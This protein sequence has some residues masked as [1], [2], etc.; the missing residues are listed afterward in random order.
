MSRDVDQPEGFTLTGIQVDVDGLAAFRTMLHLEL[1][2]NLRPGAQRIIN[3]Q[4]AGYGFGVNS[5]SAAVNYAQGLYVDALSASTNNLRMY[6]RIAQVLVDAINEIIDRYTESDL[7][8]EDLL[9]MVS[10]RLKAAN[11]AALAPNPYIAAL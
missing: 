6:M 9:N 3:D 8:G 2:K 11:A 1:E 10:A 7:S 4:M 5:E